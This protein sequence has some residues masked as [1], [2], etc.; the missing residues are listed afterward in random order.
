LTTY[1]VAEFYDMEETRMADKSIRTKGNAAGAYFVDTTCIACSVCVSEAPDTFSM[2]SDGSFAFVIKQP[3][4]DEEK[5][6][7][8]RALDACPANAIGN[9]G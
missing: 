4:S 7:A 2:S 8:E 9:D 5:T 6:D 1:S 3:A